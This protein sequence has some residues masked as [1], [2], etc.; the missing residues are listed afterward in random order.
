M[1]RE[2]HIFREMLEVASAR[3][4]PEYFQLPVADA[5]AVY[6]ERVYCYELYHQLRCVWEH[7]PLSLG[8]EVDKSG[9]PRFKD[10][11][12]A[13]AKPDLLV[14]EAGHM[15]RNLACVE[16][17]PFNRPADEF[18]ADLRKL[19]WFC[20]HASYHHGVF[21]MYGIQEQANAEAAAA[22]KAKVQAASTLLEDIDMALISVFHH[23]SPGDV[24]RLLK[25]E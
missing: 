17:K 4:G 6:R 9:H 18:A 19:T 11:P 13:R 22:L 10:G 8:G 2:W 14:H 15:D 1:K 21:I 23:P 25:F 5:D 16:V 7:F 24:V 3:I 20:R 12:Y